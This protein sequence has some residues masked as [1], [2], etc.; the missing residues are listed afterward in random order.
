MIVSSLT[1]VISKTMQSPSP[2][3]LKGTNLMEQTEPKRG[4]SQKTAGNR[5]K[6]QIGICPLKLSPN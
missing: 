4:F 6:P 5:R 2:G 1:V 3:V